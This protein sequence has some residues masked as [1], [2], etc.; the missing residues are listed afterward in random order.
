MKEYNYDPSY[1][2][3]TS[4]SECF[5]SPLNE[6][7]YLISA[8]ATLI[9]PP[10]VLENQIQIFNVNKGS[11]DVIE[12]LRGK[13]Y[14]VFT[15]NLFYNENPFEKPDNHTKIKPPIDYN[16]NNYKW[17]FET[18]SWEK[19]NLI[20]QETESTVS[21]FTLEEKLNRLNISTSELKNI[22]GIDSYFEEI[23]NL[24][25]IFEV[26]NLPIE[27]KFKFLNLDKEELKSF[28]GLSDIINSTLLDKLTMINIDIE[29]L[30]NLLE[31][32][33]LLG[34]VETC[35][36][37]QSLLL[38]KIKKFSD[39]LE[40]FF[41]KLS[42]DNLTPINLSD[43]SVLRP[44]EIIQKSE[45]FQSDNYILESFYIG[46]CADTGERKFG[47]GI[48]RWN[49]LPSVPSSQRY[50]FSRSLEMWT[51]DNPI[52]AENIECYESDTGNLKIGNGFL[53][54][55]KL[56]YEGG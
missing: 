40:N 8:S 3:Y 21:K 34:I 2:Y 51:R 37:E 9:Q 35:S 1:K 11:W 46:I 15:G 47:N 54:W 25:S 41:L 13:Y 28:I 10:D 42:T 48:D 44:I 19:L 20:Y 24:Y 27:D 50:R 4:S 23:K 18:D 55:D 56:P 16:Q 29:D 32:E 45:R 33:K 38:G 5:S 12:D 6:N 43:E 22:L 30:K 39:I 49:D 14:N 31:I 53:S 36:R 26:I 17:N 7:E 52:P